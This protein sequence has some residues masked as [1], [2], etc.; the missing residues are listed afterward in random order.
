MPLQAAT[1]TLCK[2][3]KSCEEKRMRWIFWFFLI[4]NFGVAEPIELTV[5]F[6]QSRPPYV[7]ETQ[8]DGISIRLFNAVSEELDWQYRPL[9][10]S[11]QRMKKLLEE[12]LVD[13]SVEVQPDNPSLFYSQPFIGYYNYAF[14]H[15]DIKL[16][17]SH[18]D[19]LQSFS[20]CAWQNASKHLDIQHWTTTKKNYWEYPEQKW[21]VLDW[22]NKRCEVLLIDDTLL[23]W[24]LRQFD[25]RWV[26]Y[27]YKVKI[28]TFEKVLLP[29]Q[30]N[31]L[32]FY[33]GFTD[34]ALRDDFDEQLTRLKQSGR[35]EHIRYDF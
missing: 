3:N 28:D 5:A 21:Q 29:I 1:I 34:A 30:Q 24:H 19:D 32:W 25:A 16:P 23:K 10:V 6:G 11:N 20:L 27:D 22:L 4:S 14:Y 26:K 17:L 15:S 12:G 13:I 2:P 8:G 33:V 31:P 35:Y 9:F 7:D 18:I